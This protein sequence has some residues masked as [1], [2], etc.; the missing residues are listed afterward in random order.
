MTRV[1]ASRFDTLRTWNGEQSR[2]FEEF[3]AL[4]LAELPDAV[5]KD[6]QI[7]GVR[8]K[9]PMLKGG[10]RDVHRGDEARGAHQD[11][12]MGLAHDGSEPGHGVTAV[13]SVSICLRHPA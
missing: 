12:R 5:I 11:K 10:Q 2:A 1:T 9:M 4:E 7:V 8:E 6:A 3:R 13:G